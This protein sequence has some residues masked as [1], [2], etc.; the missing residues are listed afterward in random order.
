MLVKIKFVIAGIV[1]IVA[2]SGLAGEA[3]Q[4]IPREKSEAFLNLVIGGE[5]DKAYDNI[6]QGTSI[7]TD[8]PQAIAALKKE[9]V[10]GIS[11]E[12]KAIGID[13]ITQKIY[14]SSLV[15][16]VYFLKTDKAPLV[17]DFYYY[18]TGTDWILIKINF[19]DNLKGLAGL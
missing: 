16:E 1:L 6:F 15:R 12:G 17:W 19:D 4:N 9:T 14:G 5:V 7:M 10:T 3:N 13:F 2:T 11:L 8:K 18:R